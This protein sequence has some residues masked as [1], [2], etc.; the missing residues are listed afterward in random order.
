[1]AISKACAAGMLVASSVV[2]LA[3]RAAKRISVNISCRLLLAAPSV[4]KPTLMPVFNKLG[5]GAMPLPSFALELGQW[6]T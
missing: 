2:A 4:P 6:A 5:I 1:M 3:N